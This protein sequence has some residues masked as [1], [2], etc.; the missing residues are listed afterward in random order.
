MSGVRTGAGQPPACLPA[1]LTVSGE[2]GEVSTLLLRPG[3]A[4]WLLVMAH[5]AGTDLRHRQME[6]TAQALATAGIATLRY[7]FPY[8]ESGGSRPD[9][10]PV[11]TARRSARAPSAP[12]AST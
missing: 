5:G 1:R 11:A 8:K 6:A 12:R 9:P 2:I 4:R 7:N 10:P 3:D